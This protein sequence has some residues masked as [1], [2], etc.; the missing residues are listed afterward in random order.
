MKYLVTGSCGFIG[1]NLVDMLISQGHEV[2]G[3]DNLSSDAHDNFYYNDK[4]IYYE[5]NITDCVMCSDIFNRHRPDKVF[6][7]A[8]EARIQNCINDPSKCMETN[9]LGTEIMLS[10]SK[11]YS[12]NRFVFMSTSAIYGMGNAPNVESDIPDCLNAYSFSKFFGENLCKMY[13]M[14][15]GL[16]TVCFRG[17]NI[18]GNRMPSKGQYALVIGIFK[19]LLQEGKSLTITGTGNQS[20]DFIHV[21]DVCRALIS[22]AESQESQIG[23]IYNVGSGKSITIKTIGDMM[24][25]KYNNKLPYTFI[26]SREGEAKSTEANIEKIKNKLKWEPTIEISSWINE[27]I[28]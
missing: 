23:C 10:L 12:I 19:K 1:S 14:N 25:K 6:H 7:L 9:V 4:A 16:D 27:K 17:F 22:G 2:V 5:H 15:Y 11:K 3:I 13:S 18:Y 24:K 20:R 26:P 21:D 8:A 28:F